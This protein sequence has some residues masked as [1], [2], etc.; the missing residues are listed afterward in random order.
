MQKIIINI[1]VSLFLTLTFTCY[2]QDSLTIEKTITISNP[3]DFFEIDQ[4][5]NIY[6]VYKDEVIK[7]DQNGVELYRYSNKSLGN[8][9]QI[10]VSNSLRPLIFYR[11]LSKIVVLD[12]TLSIQDNYS[13]QL[14][15]L[16]L[17]RALIIANS[18]VD[19][20]VWIYDQDQKQILKVNTK[21]ELIQETGNL[22]ILLNKSMI[23]PIQ[24]IEKNGRLYMLSK[25]DGLFIFD[26]YGSYIQTIELNSPENIQ[27]EEEFIYIWSDNQLIKYNSKSYIQTEFFLPKKYLNIKKNKDYFIALSKKGAHYDLLK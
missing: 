1:T 2:S 13:I 22:A 3:I 21:L 27:I 12:N 14:D 7:L 20:G 24:L 25:N 9:T 17:Y 19:N 8:I 16:G 26:I 6:Q 23:W 4:I 15:E 10:D 11:E 18:N 5:G